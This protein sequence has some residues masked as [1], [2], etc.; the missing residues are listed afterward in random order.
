MDSLS[1]PPRSQALK[2]FQRDGY[3]G[4]PAKRPRQPSSGSDNT[5]EGLNSTSQDW[6]ARPA[7]TFDF[8]RPPTPES[9]GVVIQE[10]MASLVVTYEAALREVVPNGE[11]VAMDLGAST[12]RLIINEH[13]L[14]DVGEHP[15]SS[16]TLAYNGRWSLHRVYDGEVDLHV[17]DWETRRYVNVDCGIQEWSYVAEFVENYLIILTATSVHLFP[18]ESLDRTAVSVDKEAS[19][20]DASDTLDL[21]DIDDSLYHR[22]WSAVVKATTYS[23][24]SSKPLAAVLRRDGHSISAYH[25]E[26]ST[27]GTNLQLSHV[28]SVPIDQQLYYISA[29]ALDEGGSNAVWI[30][31]DVCGALSSPSSACSYVMSGSLRYS[32]KLDRNLDPITLFK[33]DPGHS[34]LHCD[35]IIAINVDTSIVLAQRYSHVGFVLQGFTGSDII[36][37]NTSTA[38]TASGL[39][40]H[41]VTEP[42]FGTMGS[43]S[44]ET[45]QSSHALSLIVRI[46][47]GFAD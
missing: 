28:W 1:N 47:T 36:M 35:A 43:G 29:I 37:P 39:Q 46:L 11:S 38:P 17:R 10:N 45:R 18:M 33:S 16:D 34:L 25:L 5:E 24:E 40:D 3:M 20:V 41:T 26:R 19:F 7:V 23:T 22:S 14:K 31:H 44:Q 15:D 32:N 4:L 12:H 8:Q 2:G 27:N 21:A 9:A 30:Q 13:G 6:I 42:H